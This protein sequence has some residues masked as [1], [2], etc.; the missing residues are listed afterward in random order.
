MACAAIRVPEIAQGAPAPF[1]SPRQHIANCGMKPPHADA[2]E[3]RS[4]GRWPDT[5][6]E[7]GFARIDVSDADHYITRQQHLLDGTPAGLEAQMKC[8]GI[9]P[10]RQ[11]LR[12]QSTQELDRSGALFPVDEHDGAEA[13]R[14]VESQSASV[15]DQIEMVV[16]AGRV[17][18][19]G[20]KEP[21]RHAEMDQKQPLV[22]VKQE[23]LPA[24]SNRFDRSSDQRFRRTS[25]GPAQRL[26]HARRQHARAGNPVGKTLP[27]HFY[28]R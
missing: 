5:C 12:A 23:V 2:T 13:A 9:E 17:Q 27:R 24:P 22:Q 14:V 11:R 10:V 26:A 15:R 20:E 7:Q 8:I 25:Q 6:L 16:R 3:L 19:G 28:F 4:G 18:C 21:P 1:N